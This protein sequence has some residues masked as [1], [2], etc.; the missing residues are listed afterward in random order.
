MKGESV[1]PR[2]KDLSEHFKSIF[3]KTRTIR[4][5]FKLR[6][7]YPSQIALLF[8]LPNSFLLLGKFSIFSLSH[9]REWFLSK[10]NKQL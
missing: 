6:V 4:N 8:T 5:P 10:Q 1:S 9:I 7:S 2:N 3:S